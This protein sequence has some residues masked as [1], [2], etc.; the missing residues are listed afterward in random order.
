MVKNNKTKTNTIMK[1]ISYSDAVKRFNNN[2]ILCNNIPEFD[3]TLYDN[4]RFPLFDEHEDA[5]DIYQWY[6]TDC[7]ENDVLYLEDWY[8]LKFTYS[9]VLDKFILCVDH[10]GTP[11]SGVMIE[12]NSPEN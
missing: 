12:D 8:N 3:F 7:T 11:W 1:T 9:E 10:W 6:I 2:L 4:V 5:I